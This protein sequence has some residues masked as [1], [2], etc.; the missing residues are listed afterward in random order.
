[1]KQQYQDEE[2]GPE[3]PVVEELETPVYVHDMPEFETIEEED[4]VED[5][6]DEQ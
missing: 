4:W 3:V 6:E 2:M 5:E 1:M